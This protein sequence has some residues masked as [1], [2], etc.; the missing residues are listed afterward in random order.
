MLK[1]IDTL[2]IKL[3]LAA[4]EIWVDRQPE[5]TIMALC[6]EHTWEIYNTLKCLVVH[7]TIV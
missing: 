5:M 3:K 6:P 4:K 2:N 1:K 7:N